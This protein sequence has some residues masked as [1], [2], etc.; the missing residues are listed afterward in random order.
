MREKVVINVDE[1]NERRAN[2][3]I[4]ELANNKLTLL[5]VDNLKR[6]ISGIMLTSPT[7]NRIVSTYNLLDI[8]PST[9]G[10]LTEE[11]K[12]NI[13]MCIWSC[14][15]I[16]FEDGTKGIDNLESVDDVRYIRD[17]YYDYLFGFK[18]AE[19]EQLELFGRFGYDETNPIQVNCIGAI[20]EYF[21]RLKTTDNKSIYWDRIGSCDSVIFNGPTDKYEIVIN[22]N[23]LFGKKEKR[24]LYIN[25][26]SKT[27]STLA[28]EGFI[29]VNE[30]EA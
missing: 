12:E 1:R 15:Y 21:S 17:Q 8:Y 11:E 20:D 5:E 24:I 14:L 30:N 26:Y 22:S 27:N 23:K 4:L 2:K 9:K 16:K 25:M 19:E 13:I 29:L 10:K 18:S 6:Y 3:V 7:E 28:P